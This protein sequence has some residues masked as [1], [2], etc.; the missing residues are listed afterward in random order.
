MTDQRTRDPLPAPHPGAAA[1]L[2]LG[3]RIAMEARISTPGLLGVAA[4]VSA[5]LLGSAAIVLAARR[6]GPAAPPERG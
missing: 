6:S 1:S 4:I 5:A 3:N 2:R